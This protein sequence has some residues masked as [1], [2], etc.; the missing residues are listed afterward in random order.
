MRNSC[1]FE[2]D[3][4]GTLFLPAGFNAHAFI[5]P[6][7]FRISYWISLA[8]VFLAGCVS[9]PHEVVKLH[10]REG[11]IMQELQRTHL[12][13]IDAYVDEKVKIFEDFY[14]K[15]YG[16]VYRRNWESSFQKLSGR[17]YDADKDF[18][19][20]Y[21]DLVATYQQEIE[22]LNKLRAELRERIV[23]AHQQAAEAHDAVS[24]WIHSVERL[25]TAQ[26]DAA[27]RLLSSVSPS[28]SLEKIDTKVSEMT[29][30]LAKK[31]KGE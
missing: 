24:G 4:Q 25:N 27:N 23:T 17:P 3:Q 19:L 15:Q 30:N 14:F 6:M 16:P 9:A 22:P 12:V 7:M 21:N 10:D 1:L 28:L 11:Q 2:D 31:M 26:R 13:M 20:M 8:A 29:T 5:N 18:A